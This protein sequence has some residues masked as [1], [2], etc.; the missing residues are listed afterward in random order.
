MSNEFDFINWI[1]SQQTPA[2]VV[3]LGI[4]DDLAVL[5]WPKDDLLLVGVDQ[6]LD[7]VHFDST[8]HSPREIGRKAMNRNLSDCAAMACSPAAA[9]VSV[10]FT[11]GVRENYAQ[12]LYLGIKEAGDA[13]NCVIVGGDTASW[14]GKLIVSVSILA[15]SDGIS[16]VLRSGAKS[17]D[18]IYITGPTGGSILGRHMTFEPR[19]KLARYLAKNFTINAMADLSDGLFRDLR[20]IC[21]ASEV[22]AVLMLKSLPIHAD[23]GRLNDGKEDAVHA[24][25]DGEDYELL[26][27]SPDTLPEP[28]VLIG[29]IQTQAGL[30]L[31][32]GSADMHLDLNGLV[33]WEHQF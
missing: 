7:G 15:R 25:T 2:D 17:G 30:V 20:N 5:N 12:E 4:G 24:M 14:T 13:F 22:G 6:V 23:V 21:Q 1:K 18:G 16:P 29:H 11:K 26:V 31:D 10:V 3:R 32:N 27:I 9:L 28:C 8:V 33:G 19:V